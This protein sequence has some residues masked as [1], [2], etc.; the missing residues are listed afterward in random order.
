MRAASFNANSIRN[1][2]DVI[3]DWMS[4]ARC[5]IIGIQETKCQDKDFP[6]EQ[7]NERG[8]NC[9]FKGQKT[10]NGV[11]II[12]R[13]ELSD[14]EY[15]IGNAD[16]DTEAR[17]IKARI[18]DVVFVNTYIPQ[19]QTMDSD[20][21]ETKK[22]YLKEVKRYFTDNYTPLDK[23]IWVGDFNI[24][25]GPLDVFD[26]NIYWGGVGY[27]DIEIGL[28][29]DIKS[30]G[31]SDTFRLHHSD[32]PYQFTFW[33]Y[34]IPAAVK[35]KMGWRIDYIMATDVLRNACVGSYIDIEPRNKPKPSDHTFLFSDFNIDLYN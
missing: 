4:A 14:V 33:D 29:D 3:L 28:L 30:W 11:A 8:F 21:F 27:N 25:S 2:L 6:I 18:G 5:D 31:L 23:I 13:H 17:F 35:R 20:K 24:A 34:R 26:P 1:R 32:E 19:G 9:V 7:I 12:S 15:E 10:F 16:L 22:D